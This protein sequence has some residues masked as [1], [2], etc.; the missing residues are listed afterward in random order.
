MYTFNFLYDN[1]KK[2]LKYI[3]LLSHS[4]KLIL[5]FLYSNFVNILNDFSKKKEKNSINMRYIMF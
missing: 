5:K 1:F 3:F 4:T 2:K